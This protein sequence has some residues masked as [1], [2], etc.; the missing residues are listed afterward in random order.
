MMRSSLLFLLPLAAN[1]ALV[2]TVG[3]M[4]ESCFVVRIPQGPEASLVT[5][6]F[7]LLDDSLVPDPLSVVLL[8]GKLEQIYKSEPYS[9]SGMFSVSATGRVSLCVRN[10]IESPG[11]KDKKLRQ[12]GLDV[13]V[14]TLDAT[15]AMTEI[16]Q[17][18]QSKVWNFKS[19]YDYMITRHNRHE[20]MVDA[21][22]TRLLVWSL[23]E[24]TFVILASV[25]QIFYMRRFV[26]RRRAF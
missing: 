17:R 16:V 3:H 9:K 22:F 21:T 7:D 5:G 2:I 10:G 4:D 19:H 12:V 26:E 20:D 8:N 23:V 13:Q 1:A 15:S 18:V 6:S 25:A 24:A 14:K 11:R